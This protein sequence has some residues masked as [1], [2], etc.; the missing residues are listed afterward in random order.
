M[1]LTQQ[2]RGA[3]FATKLTNM[4]MPEMN[5]SELSKKLQASRPEL[6]TLFMSGFYSVPGSIFSALSRG[7]AT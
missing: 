1:P 2:K 7:L 6:K 3:F 5:G 4:M